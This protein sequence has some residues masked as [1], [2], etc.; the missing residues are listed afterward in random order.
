MLVT[1][2]TGPVSSVL[3]MGGFSVWNLVNS[4]AGMTAMV[5]LNVLLVPR[6]GLTGAAIAGSV[7]IMSVQLAA[8]IEVWFL[9]R[10]EPLGRGF[11]TVALAAIGCVGAPAL[12]SRAILGPTIPGFVL[13]LLVAVPTYLFVL[14]RS[15]TAL[16]FAMLREALRG[17]KG[18]Y[19]LVD[20][21]GADRVVPEP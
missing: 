6:Y 8:A 2:A 9:L 21:V 16:R 18:G 3:L 12:L 11:R 10:L 20:E 15:A 19:R 17:G 7:A 1:M 4:I 13:T 5:G 14:R